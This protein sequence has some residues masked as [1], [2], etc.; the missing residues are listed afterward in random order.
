MGYIETNKPAAERDELRVLT[1][2]G[3]KLVPIKLPSKLPVEA[4]TVILDA[5]ASAVFDEIT[6]QG[7]TEDLN[8]WPDTFRQGQ[9]IPAIE[10]LRANRIRTL[11]MREMEE[12]MSQVDLYVGGRDLTLTNLTGHPSVV[13]PNGLRR[14]AAATLR[15][16]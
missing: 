11:V 7:V 15:P 12:V 4:L 16:P 5:E 10:Y 8:A 9:F 1:D 6:R 2:L 3:V 14:A 13:L